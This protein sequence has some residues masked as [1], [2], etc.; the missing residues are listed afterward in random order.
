MQPVELHSTFQKNSSSSAFNSKP[1]KKQ[2][3]A[4][5]DNMLVDFRQ[6]KWSLVPEHNHYPPSCLG[7]P[8]LMLKIEVSKKG[9]KKEKFPTFYISLH[10]ID[11]NPMALVK[12][13]IHHFSHP[14]FNMVVAIF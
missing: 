7:S 4:G 2:H 10:R 5:K 6:T 14:L 13:T 1:G 3:E 12:E 11:G 9:K 8:V